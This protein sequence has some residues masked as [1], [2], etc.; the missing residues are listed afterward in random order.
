MG[1]PLRY[2]SPTPYRRRAGSGQY[3]G[4]V[5]NTTNGNPKNH[6]VAVVEFDTVQGFNDGYHRMGNHIGVNFNSLTSDFEGPILFYKNEEKEELLLQTGDPI[7]ADIYR[8][9]EIQK[10]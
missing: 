6:V 2:L 1:S 10:Y 4:L 7:K 3:M 8:M 5:N 9:T